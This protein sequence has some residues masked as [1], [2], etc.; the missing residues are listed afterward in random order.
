MSTFKRRPVTNTVQAEQFT[1]DHL[2]S[3]VQFSLTGGYYVITLQGN[4]VPVS[5]TEWIVKEVA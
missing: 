4:R 1:P 3:G 5:H 2:P